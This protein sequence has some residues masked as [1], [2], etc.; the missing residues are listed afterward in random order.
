MEKGKFGISINVIAVIAFIFVILRQPQSVL[1]VVGF[2]LLAEKNEWL[3]KQV[4]Q[5]LFLIITY[6]LA[7]FVA[8][9]IFGG[10]ASFFGSVNIYEAS[11]LILKINSFIAGILLIVLVV[12]S[13]M[14]ILKVLKGQDAGIPY[15]STIINTTVPTFAPKVES[16]PGKT[17]CPNCSAALDEDAMF[18]MECGTKV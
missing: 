1:L 5:S 2:A 17:T 10:I 16:M 11:G 15:F 8:D 14:A 13:I 4:I 3:N 12:F 6:Y 9:F 18:C 7:V